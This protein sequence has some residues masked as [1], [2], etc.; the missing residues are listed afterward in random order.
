MKHFVRPAVNIDSRR[1]LVRCSDET[2]E[3][4]ACSPFKMRSAQNAHRAHLRCRDV[5]CP[6]FQ[7]G[8]VLIDFLR[9]QKLLE[10]S[11]EHDTATRRA[12]RLLATEFDGIVDDVLFWGIDG[13]RVVVGLMYPREGLG[14]DGPLVLPSADDSAVLVA[15]S[16]E[17]LREQVRAIEG[18]YA[19]DSHRSF[20]W[21]QYLNRLAFEALRSH[22]SAVAGSASG[23]STND[24]FFELLDP[25]DGAGN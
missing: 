22:Q 7:V 17:Q 8:R 14:A 5:G 6:R 21:N 13:L 15:F 9:E 19:E 12:F 3:S 2:R 25:K 1:P 20:S 11:H 4:L 18:N 16:F 24:F 23:L 10:I